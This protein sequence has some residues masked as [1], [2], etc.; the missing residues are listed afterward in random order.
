M[1]EIPA[2]CKEK[3][4]KSIEGLEWKIKEDKGG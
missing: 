3:I 4:S 2:K 1:D